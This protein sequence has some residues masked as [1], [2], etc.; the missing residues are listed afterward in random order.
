[1]DFLF[2]I[3][4]STLIACPW[5]LPRCIVGVALETSFAFPNVSAAWIKT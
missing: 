3:N 5:W 1:M 2:Y 4:F